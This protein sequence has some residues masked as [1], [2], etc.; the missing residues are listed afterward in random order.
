MSE[1]FIFGAG[2]SHASG[3]TPLG[4]DLVWNYYEDC[5]T[6]YAIGSDERPTEADL[7]DKRREF[8][9][10]GNFLLKIQDRYPG[11]SGIS[12]KWD[13]A[14]K[15][16]EFFMLNI[17]K[18]YYIDEIMEGLILDEKYV[19]DIHLIKRVAS[20]HIS[21]MSGIHKNDFYKKFVKNLKNKT[22]DEVSIISFNFDCLLD[23]DL[24]E[25]IYFDYL[26]KFDDIDSRRCFY[27][28]GRGIS[29]IKLHGSLDWKLDAHTGVITLLPVE[30]HESYGGEPCIFLPHE[31]ANRKIS[32]LWD[33][34]A[35]SVRGAD[36]I[37]F[38]GY[39]LPSYDLDA[40]RLFQSNVRRETRI[41]IIDSSEA[42]I[43]R[44][45][46]LFPKCVTEGIVCD[47]SI[48]CNEKGTTVLS[49]GN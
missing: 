48:Q 30:W 41:E 46:K 28:P 4:K 38:F 6:W 29:L 32:Q 34:A 36:K 39:S 21:K 15:A 43:D 19:D 26:I 25:Q 23:D 7:E 49:L 24:D 10:F 33:A 13:K 40:T 47:L 20:Q 11:L 37:T 1:L 3:G 14:M 16:G 44:Y 35:E 31:Q 5:S 27:K 45:K 17:E 42:T 22:R 9:D 2:A 8:A 12:Q 18:P